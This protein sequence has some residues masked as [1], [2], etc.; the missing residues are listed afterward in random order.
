MPRPQK[1]IRVF[2]STLT[3]NYQ[4]FA[5]QHYQELKNDAGHVIGYRITGKKYDVTQDIA[6]AIV[7]NDI[8]FT[9]VSKGEV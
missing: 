2:C 8:E 1:P 7:K 5:S 6:N 9:P 3:D 4:F